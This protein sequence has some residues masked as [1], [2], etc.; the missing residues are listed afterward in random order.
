MIPKFFL[1]VFLSTVYGCWDF[2]C[3]YQGVAMWLLSVDI[4]LLGY[5]GVAM[6]LLKCF[7]FCY[8]I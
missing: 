5:Q 7:E 3:G 6:Q 8:C 4:C 1:C 2:L